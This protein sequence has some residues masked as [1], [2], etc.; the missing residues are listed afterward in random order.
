M[1]KLRLF[2]AVIAVLFG[3]KAVAQSPD[4]VF[5][6]ANVL[7]QQGKFE[8]A[9]DAYEQL[10]HNGYVGGELFYNLGNCYYKTGN[11]AGAILSYERARR[12]IPNDEDLKHNLT[13]ANL[14]ITDRIEP[15]PRLF[16]WDVWDTVKN[17]FSF[18]TVTLLLAVAY[19]LF[20]A[21][22]AVVLLARKYPVRKY[23]FL[24]GMFFAPVFV[25]LVAIFLG[26]IAELQRDDVAV[27]VAQVTTV[28][29]SPDSKSSDAFVLHSGVKVEITDRVNEWIKIRL[30][31]G[32][33]GWVEEGAAEVL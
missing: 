22:F 24:S 7:Y 21:A 25:L 9:R 33:V 28:K 31:D 10:V 17:A 3:S 12:F 14:M 19:V 4:Q 20:I 1:M 6:N 27:M 8:E 11:V 16:L 32:K 2:A 18:D 29:N 13:L 23:A 15:A 30:A 26:K 5:E